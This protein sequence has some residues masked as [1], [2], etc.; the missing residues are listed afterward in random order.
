LSVSLAVGWH[1]LKFACAVMIAGVKNIHAYSWLAH[2]RKYLE[3]VEHERR[4][5]LAAKVNK[6]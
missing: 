5:S 4:H 1:S 6:P 3:S 2:S